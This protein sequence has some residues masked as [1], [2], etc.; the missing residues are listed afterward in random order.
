VAAALALPPL[1]VG[2][3]SGPVLSQ[4][5]T[6]ASPQAASRLE[7]CTSALPAMAP[8][9]TDDSA[10]SPLASR[11]ALRLLGQARAGDFVVV[12]RAGRVPSYI[13]TAERDRVLAG[14]AGERRLLCD[15]GRFQLWS[16]AAASAVAAEARLARTE[17][18]TAPPGAGRNAHD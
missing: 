10:A 13:V 12:D 14:L 11:P 15:D 8:V 17:N 7:R 6:G 16:P 4:H 3:L 5:G 18:T 1:V 9:A 2:A